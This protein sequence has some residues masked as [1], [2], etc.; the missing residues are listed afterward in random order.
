MSVQLLPGLALLT[1]ESTCQQN[2]T[3]SSKQANT[4]PGQRRGRYVHTSSNA[5]IVHKTLQ[6]SGNSVVF[7]NDKLNGIII[8]GIA[9]N[10]GN[11]S[12]SVPARSQT[13]DVP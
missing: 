9:F 11:F 10:R 4:N 1:P 6:L 8:D 3:G 2:H 7:I 5:G 12:D 13:V